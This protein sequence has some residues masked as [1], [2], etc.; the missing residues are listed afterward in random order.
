MS[1]EYCN[2]DCYAIAGVFI[3]GNIICLGPM[4]YEYEIPY[5]PW[6]GKKLRAEP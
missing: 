3:E 6:C 5:C 4:Q 2:N 1:E